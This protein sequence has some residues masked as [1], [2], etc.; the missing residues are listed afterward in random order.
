M[1]KKVTTRSAFFNPRALFGFALCALGLALA[2]I[3]FNGLAT[4][5]AFA[6]DT[7]RGKAAPSR[8]EAPTTAPVI[9]EGVVPVL[10]RPLREMK[11]A[12]PSKE[13]GR[14]HPEPIYP[15][16]ASDAR[17]TDAAIQK[18]G[19]ATSGSPNATGVSFDGVGV[20]LSNFT[21]NSNPPDTVGQVGP[22]QYVQF[23]NTSLAVFDKN[24]GALLM[25]P[26]LG[27]QLFQALGGQCAIHNDGDPVVNYDILSGR[28]V[29]SQF[30]I[31]GPAGSF[32]HQCIAVSQTQDATGAYYLYDFVT[33]PNNFIDYEKVAVWPDGYYMSGHV[34]NAAGT[35][36]LMGR[37]YSFERSQML[38]GAPARMVSANMPTVAGSQQI[39]FV[40]AEVQS[41]TPPPPGEAEFVIGPGPT[42]SGATP[43][44]SSTRVSVSWGA[45]PTMTLG[46]TA[47]IPITPYTAP[48]CLVS[49]A[50]RQCV[51][52]PSPAATT[53]YV[54]RIA[55]RFML[56]LAYRNNGTVAAPQESI[57]ATTAAGST[58]PTSHGAIRW[59]EF[60]NNGDSAATPTTFQESTY[61]P[62]GSYRWIPSIAMDK[63][64]NIAIGYSKSSTTVKPSIY[65]AGRLASDAINTMGAEVSMV[66]GPGVQIGGGN[67]WGDY[68]AMTL[69]P[70]DQCSFYYTNEYLK[71]NGAFN[72][73]TRVA[74]FKFP[75]CVSAPAWGT[76]SGHIISAQTGAP[77]QGVIVTLTGGYSAA[78]DANGNYSVLAPPGSYNAVAT[79][80]LRNCTYAQPDTIPVFISSGGNSS[81]NF[82]IQGNSKLELNGMQ[83]DDSTGNANG[84][85]NK[86]ECVK[87]N[88]PLKNNGCST[89]TAVNA[90]LTTSTPGVTVLDSSS[91]YPDMIIDAGGT[92]ATPFRISV[93]PS[94]VCGT[95][96]ALTLNLTYAGG[97]KAINFTVPSCT[98]GANQAIP[99]SQLT[100]SSPTQADRIGRG[101]VP[102]SCAGKAS[103]GGGFTATGPH[104][105]QTYNFTNDGGAPACFTVTINAG[106]GGPGDIESVAYL[107]TYDPANISTNYL[108]DSGIS[109]LGTTVGSASYSFTVPALSNFVVV[110]ETSGNATAGGN[111]SS[112]FSGTVSGFYNQTPGP[113]ICPA[114]PAAPVLTG[115]ASRVNGLDTPIAISGTV[116]TEPRFGGAN[117]NYTVVLNF[118]TP[119]NGGTAS[120][121]SGTG[122]AGTPTFSGNS[123]IIPLSG[124]TNLQRV[125][126]RANNVTNTSGGILGSTEVTLGFVLADT[127]GDGV[128]N[129]GDV[130]QTKSQSGMTVTAANCREDINA[131]G[132][133]NSGDVMVAK[134]RSGTS[135]P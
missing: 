36:F 20:G 11:L 95:N 41:L 129:A 87:L 27:N 72:W 106:L 31:G 105:Y 79:D 66:D 88:F 16:I 85:I 62:D 75:S 52:Q 15:E 112:V 47:S 35:S 91:T 133:I 49:S 19:Y 124:V 34:F 126:V 5:L 93:D 128:V 122:T 114:A 94:F 96:I 40:P 102:S 98:G 90:T 77:V 43:T 115:A 39:G 69:D 135:L 104:Y 89:E 132:T 134:S 23:V 4:N 92:N 25:G 83:V 22:T 108:G 131:D 7:S 24:T 18:D 118:D 68:S 28:W 101:G 64:Q 59:W 17:G 65:V 73:S 14:V 127:N 46:P 113:G 56:R 54:D 50:N 33:D 82:T 97:N 60:R 44:A 2:L 70:V 12:A 116:G 111:A 55:T 119:I 42:V 58:S 110:V 100:T 121:V 117:G 30:L 26:L 67:R 3:A 1:K 9:S 32:S 45:T 10:S 13:P 107:N 57:L 76:L 63:D 38:I 8:I 80:P 81:Q 6:Q 48:P 99:S 78:T 109:G 103:P 71:T 61:D 29:I 130:A 74:S 86:A 84:V 21:P 37:M 120:V 53:D 123:M 51:P 125:T